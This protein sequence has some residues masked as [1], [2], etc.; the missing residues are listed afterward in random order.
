MAKKNLDK[1]GKVPAPA[2]STTSAQQAPTT[3]PLSIQEPKIYNKILSSDE[4]K[5]LFEKYQPNGNFEKDFTELCF[6]LDLPS[7]CS[8]LDSTHFSSKSVAIADIS[9][10]REDKKLIL[11]QDVN[12][13]GII[14]DKNKKLKVDITVEDD[15]GKKVVKELHVRGWK[16]DK[17]FVTILT[18]TIPD[19]EKINLIDF[20]NTGLDD[21]TLND[22]A[23]CLNTLTSLRTLRLDGNNNISNQRFDMFITEKSVLQNLSLRCCNLD[24]SAAKL[25][26][27]ALLI[28]KSLLTLNL[29]FN[30]I[31]DIGGSYIA[32]SLSTFPLTH[33]QV[34]ARRMLLSSFSNDDLAVS[35]SSSISTEHDQSSR[36]FSKQEDKKKIKKKTPVK[37][38]I[39]RG[40]SSID[41]SKNPKTSKNKSAKTDHLVKTPQPDVEDLYEFK[42]PLLEKVNS[43]NKEL[44]IPGNRSLIILNLSRNKITN[45]GLVSLLEAIKYQAAIAQEMNKNVALGLMR[46][47]LQGNSF[48]N[49]H[50]DYLQLQQLMK[51]RD[52]FYVQSNRDTKS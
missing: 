37:D 47:S 1:S 15:G 38:S 35:P 3:Q 43:I 21:H 13:S 46:L 6:L 2:I 27:D 22:L 7:V 18:A 50:P 39:K 40:S 52:P 11:P 16:L 28:N 45:I 33:E 19:L 32:K 30:K 26:S 4:K 12:S 49:N 20:W 17:K 29:C 24:D 5:A 48:D 23:I 51:T 34:V 44:W 41:A 36:S 8:T 10:N 25:I 31:T 14:S 42:N 9:K